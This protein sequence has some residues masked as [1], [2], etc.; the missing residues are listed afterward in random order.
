MWTRVELK[1]KAKDFLRMYYWKAFLVAFMIFIVGG[2]QNMLLNSG[3]S[4]GRGGQ[5]A[6]YQGGQIIVDDPNSF[7]GRFT[8]LMGTPGILALSIVIVIFMIGFFLVFRFF[9]G[10]PIEIGGRKFFLDGINEEPDV[11]S[12]GWVFKSGS[13]MN[14]SITMFLT[15]IY[16]FLWFL[17]LIIPGIIKHY[18]YMMVPYILVENPNIEPSKAIRQSIQMTQGHKMNMFIL[19]L[20]FLGWYILGTLM[21]GIG[22]L[23]V[24]PYYEA[25]YAQL[26]VSLKD[27]TTIEY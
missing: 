13:Y 9:I 15:G 17:L 7:V 12:L 25:T 21:L 3:G 5:D 23:F 27:D 26:Y 11:K 22:V 6:H 10:I 16:N 4:S 24:N 8:E 20:S 18:S 1:S 19:D 14:I 2:N